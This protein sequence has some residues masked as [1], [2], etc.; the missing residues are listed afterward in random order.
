MGGVN[1]LPHVA[2]KS[3]ADVSNPSSSCSANGNGKFFISGLMNQP[4]KLE[5]VN[6][7]FHMTDV[8]RQKYKYFKKSFIFN[9]NWNIKFW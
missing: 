7:T 8:V 1:Q 9:E 5:I 3:N 2:M 4:N 6:F